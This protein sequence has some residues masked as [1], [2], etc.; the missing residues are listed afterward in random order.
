LVAILHPPSSTL[1]LFVVD[2]DP[3]P[4]G[5]TTATPTSI[6]TNPI[7]IIGAMLRRR[8]RR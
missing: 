5:V 4:F 8:A 3:L 6:N 2:P 7:A 1:R